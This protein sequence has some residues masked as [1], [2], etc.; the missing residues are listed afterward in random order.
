MSFENMSA[1]NRNYFG[2]QRCCSF[3][4]RIGHRIN[5]C[6]DIRLYNFEQ[7]CINFIRNNGIN[8]FNNY[9]LDQ[10]IVDPNVVRAFAIKKCNVTTRQQID[11]CISRIHE[12]FVNIHDNQN[13]TQSQQ[14]MQDDPQTIEPLTQGPE[15][16][17][18]LNRESLVRTMLHLMTIRETLE[19]SDD[20]SLFINM[21]TQINQSIIENR[22]FKI[23]TNIINHLDE[24]NEQCEYEC[25]ICYEKCSKSKFV[26]FNCNH[27][28]C[29]DCVKKSLQN[30]TKMALNCAFCRSKITNFEVTDLSIK[31][32]FI[33]FIDE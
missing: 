19:Q 22:K 3:C 15:G 6:N 23:K 13:L 10:A 7:T 29:K 28:F 5:N 25:N 27:E 31:N 8:S 26:K 33:E 24:T 20:Y 9:L 1:E 2:L 4:R 21:I 17:M 18:E 11:V 16:S 14:G 30:E 12:Y 32:E